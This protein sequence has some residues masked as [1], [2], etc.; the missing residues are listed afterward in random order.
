[1]QSVT[2]EQLKSFAI[3]IAGTLEKGVIQKDQ[4]G[5][6]RTAQN[7]HIDPD[8]VATLLYTILRDIGIEVRD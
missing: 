2:R 1:M 8:Q 4:Y 3:R 7:V 5:N 6:T